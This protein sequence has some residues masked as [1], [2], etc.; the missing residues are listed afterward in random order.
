[1]KIEELYLYPCRGIPGIKVDSL[2]LGE[3]G[4]M[5]DRIFAII[6]TEN[7]FPMSGTNFPE[8]STLRQRIEGDTL[9]LSS[10]FPERLTTAGLATELRLN[11]VTFNT[12]ERV[13][14]MKRHTG[15]KCAAHMNLWVTTAVK[16][17]AFLIRSSD[18]R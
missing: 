15:F 7:L 6:N 4:I 9:I 1:M 17:D 12:D 8:I 5:H 13:E 3:Y 16:K 18:D 2:H 11:M 10:L 14:C